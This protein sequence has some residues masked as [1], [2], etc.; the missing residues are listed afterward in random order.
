MCF[1]KSKCFAKYDMLLLTGSSTFKLNESF[2]ISRLLE[3]HMNVN[4][5]FLHK[6]NMKNI[7]LNKL[8]LANLETNLNHNSYYYHYHFYIIYIILILGSCI[9]ML[10]IVV[11]CKNKNKIDRTAQDKVASSTN[12]LEENINNSNDNE[13]P[14]DALKQAKKVRNKTNSK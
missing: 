7:S 6:D 11:N 3:T 10:T 2:Q 14:K 4:F 12:S 1:W 9:L 8:N 13:I 5:F